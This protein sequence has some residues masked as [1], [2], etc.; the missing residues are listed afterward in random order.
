LLLNEVNRQI[1]GGNNSPTINAE[2]FLNVLNTEH[3][4]YNGE[5][6]LAFQ[7]EL[8]K[9]QQEN[10]KELSTKEIQKLRSDP[11]VAERLILQIL[12]ADRAYE[13]DKIFAVEWRESRAKDDSKFFD[14]KYR[15]NA[16]RVTKE[17]VQKLWEKFL[18]QLPPSEKQLLLP[19][20]ERQ[21]LHG[22]RQK[23]AIAKRK[24][25][26]I[27]FTTP[28]DEQPLP[29]SA[30][31]PIKRRK[32]LGRP[33]KDSPYFKLHKLVWKYNRI[34]QKDVDKLEFKPQL[35]EI[36]VHVRDL[37]ETR[38][39]SDPILTKRDFRNKIHQNVEQCVRINNLMCQIK[40]ATNVLLA[41]NV[42]PLEID[43]DNEEDD[44]ED[45]EEDI[46]EEYRGDD[47]EDDES[48]H[49][50]EDR[51]DYKENGEPFEIDRDNEEDDDEDN[52]EEIDENNKGVVDEDDESKDFGKDRVPYEEHENHSNSFLS[53]KVITEH[54]PE[55]MEQLLTMMQEIAKGKS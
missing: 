11:I 39:L 12:E 24:A 52:E 53:L 42:E 26:T 32:I 36:K 3:I 21:L 49:I 28:P 1:S 44:D 54:T 9:I 29:I 19:P 31:E 17:Y 15:D 6:S 41:V 5:I 2:T 25:T 22:Y 40:N 50:E 51:E 14:F 8:N 35:N 55:E 46:D 4:D 7:E 20:S 18:T 30:E 10:G 13:G 47:D 33:N 43:E 23:R 45:T 37:V 27:S 48:E 38:N 16:L 34:N